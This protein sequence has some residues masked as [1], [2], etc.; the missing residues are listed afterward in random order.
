M[1]TPILMELTADIVSAHVGHNSVAPADV[2]RLIQS[3][4][5]ALAGV[6]Q[7]APA[8]AA[9]P[10]PKVAVRSSV[11]PDAITCLEC[12]AKM[13]ILKRH[14]ATDH[15]FSPDEYRLRWSLPRD[16]PMVAPDYSAKRQAVAKAFGLGRRADKKV[17][18]DQAKAMALTDGG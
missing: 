12:G 13:K 18:S 3:V 15:G 14:L 16:Y 4:Y 9:L 2:P 1:D 6:G 10:E 11:K 5:G 8:A 7:E 17:P